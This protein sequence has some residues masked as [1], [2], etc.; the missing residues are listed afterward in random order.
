VS[1]MLDGTRAEARQGGAMVNEPEKKTNRI[2]EVITRRD[3]KIAALIRAGNE[4]V[5]AMGT[6]DAERAFKALHVWRALAGPLNAKAK[7]AAKAAQERAK[8]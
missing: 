3:V 6:L 8:P 7:D 4:L 5:A 1:A 2:R